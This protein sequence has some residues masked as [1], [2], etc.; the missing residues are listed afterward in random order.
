MQVGH[1]QA[2]LLLLEGM[3][4]LVELLDEY[5]TVQ[6]ASILLDGLFPRGFSGDPD[7]ALPLQAQAA[8]LAALG[9]Y[10]IELGCRSGRGNATLEAAGNVSP[11]MRGR[12]DSVGPVLQDTCSGLHLELICLQVEVQILKQVLQLNLVMTTVQLL[13]FGA[14]TLD[15]VELEGR[16]DH[17]GVMLGGRTDHRC[18][19]HVGWGSPRATGHVHRAARDR[20]VPFHSGARIPTTDHSG[21][22]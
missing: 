13:P 11:T 9:I 17:F 3:S 19:I 6:L 21:Q 5:P 7:D 8:S 14:I 16:H 12:G 10:H 18:L 22:T 20:L 15:P 2:V 4:G 1:G